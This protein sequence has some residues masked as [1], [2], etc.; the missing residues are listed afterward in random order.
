[1]FIAEAGVNHNGSLELAHRLIDV[2]ADAGA[3]A[4][5]FQAFDP[6]R[7]AAPAAPQAAYQRHNTGIAEPQVEMLRR[8]ALPQDAWGPLRDHAAAR[9]LL[10]LATPFDEVSADLLYGL[11]VPGFKVAS[12]E[13][14]NLPFLACLA[15]RGLP[16]LLST[17]MSTLPEVAEAV[18]TVREHG[19]PPLA[20]LHCVTNYPAE[21]ADCNLNAMGTMRSAFGVPV[22][23][24][25]HTEGIEISLAAVALGAELLEKHFTLDRSMAGPDHRASLA[26]PELAA[27]VKAARRVSAARGD[28]R[29]VPA[30]SELLLAAVGRR[31]LHAARDLAPGHILVPADVVALRPGSGLPPSALGRLVGRRVATRVRSGTMLGEQQFE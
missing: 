10:F 2:A 25:D 18:R 8:L 9:D 6:D 5:K 14:T 21:P 19:N 3:D 23:W 20:L 15:G 29:K 31:S 17:G 26:P 1:M 27:L 28:G 12:G 11:G 16:V 7:L 22:G 30:A 4:V 13:V 24:S